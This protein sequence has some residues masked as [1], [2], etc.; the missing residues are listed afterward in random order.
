MLKIVKVKTVKVAR[1]SGG[2]SLVYLWR[3]F[4]LQTDEIGRCKVFG[5]HQHQIELDWIGYVQGMHEA[6][7]SSQL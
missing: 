1:D 7:G 6:Q 5:V 3:S 4:G 2:S